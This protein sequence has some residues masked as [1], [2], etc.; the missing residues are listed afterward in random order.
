[1]QS[2][3]D[4]IVL[5]CGGGGYAAAIRASQ[6]GGKVAVV[7][8]G[9][10]GGTCVNR[11]CIPSKVWLRASFMLNMINKSQEFG[12]EVSKSQINLKKIVERKNGVTTE[13]RIGMESLLGSYGID[14][15][16]GYGI[17]KNPC[18]IIVNENTLTS[19]NII[20]AT[21]SSSIIP[22]I[23]GL[24][25]A[26]MKTD[27]VFDMEAVP[28]SLLV[29]G[30]GGHIGVEIASLLNML[31]SKVYLASQS[32]RILSREDG[33]T[34]QRLAQALREQGVNILTGVDLESVKQIK[35][36][37]DVKLTGKNGQTINVDK[38]LVT[39]RRPGTDGIGINSIGL[40][41]NE[42]K[43]VRVDDRLQTSVEGI[44]AVGDI[45]G[46]WMSSHAASAMAVTAAEN[47]MGQTGRFPSHLIPR[48]I[49]TTPQVGAVGLSEEEAEKKGFDVDTGSFPYAINALAICY[50]EV[51]GA[52]KIVFDEETK[53][54]L[55]VHIVG[56]HATELIGEAV[57]ALQLEC[58]IDEL[59][60]TLRVHPTFS[61]ALMDAGR[62][63]SHWALYL[64]KNNMR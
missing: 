56:P 37:H 5:G 10:I 48:G 51:E 44:Y 20:L 58:T 26:I 59:S 62:E 47:A 17:L 23:P 1:M 9:D 32:S 13:I 45:T 53:A 16:K 54:V 60:H 22:K 18:E 33:E 42:D 43:S 14:L 31:G 50:D 57:M 30:D 29:W 25:N 41:L 35:D 38:V 27:Q 15:V 46:G 19:K 55:G 7:E 49:W 40:D 28:P 36:S 61:E 24:A 34:G 11:G 6:L 21:G 3:Y 8:A 39:A 2:T 4:V 12:I 52:V 63:A 64:P